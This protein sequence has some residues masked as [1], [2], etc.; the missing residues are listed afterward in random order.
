M[1]R[2]R[3]KSSHVKPPPVSGPACGARPV[4]SPSTVSSVSKGSSPMSSNLLVIQGGG[5]P[6]VLNTTLYGILDEAAAAPAIGQVF[7]ARRGIT[8]IINNDLL[9][10]STLSAAQRESLKTSP[11]AS[12]GSTRHRPT[13][14]DLEKIIT[15]LRRHNIRYLLLIGGNGSL[16]GAEAI[17]QACLA[18]NYEIAV[19]GVPKTVDND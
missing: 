2:L 18:A 11:G 13:E 4:A 14:T 15:N 3:S 5:P 10:L 6:P 8:G 16:R 9:N 1:R 12:L 17:R 19:I 7:G